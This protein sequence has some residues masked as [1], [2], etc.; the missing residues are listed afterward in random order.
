MKQRLILTAYLLLIVG[1][2]SSCVFALFALAVRE[3]LL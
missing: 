2:V 3:Y 1:I